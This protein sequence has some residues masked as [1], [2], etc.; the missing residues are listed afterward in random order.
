[1][2]HAV[3]HVCVPPECH[4]AQVE[5]LDV[6]VVVSSGDATLRVVVGV[7]EGDRPAVRRC[8]AL[9]GFQGNHGVLL[10]RVPNPHGPVAA[11]GDQLWCTIANAQAA[12]AVHGVDDLVVALDAPDG[13][14]HVLQVPD[15]QVASVV[16]RGQVPLLY[17]RCTERA[18]L[19][20]LGLLDL[21]QLLTLPLVQLAHPDDTRG[22]G[23]LAQ[24]AE[25]RALG[26][27]SCLEGGEVQVLLHMLDDLRSR[28]AVHSGGACGAAGPGLRGARAPEPL[29]RLAPKW[30]R[31]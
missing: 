30:L 20:A 8:L 3:P 12:D 27:P 1:M 18:A 4:G 25:A 19:E 16:T 14:L 7:A 29:G 31:A 6:A 28:C 13:A 23:H 2:A 24:D 11:A 21:H 15:V 9:N 17:G 5:D 22:A 10:P 26:H